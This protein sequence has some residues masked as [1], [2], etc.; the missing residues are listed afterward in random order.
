M[1]LTSFFNVVS[2]DDDRATVN[3]T[4]IDQMIPDA[5]KN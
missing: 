3:A 4:Q 1:S 5:I 2:S